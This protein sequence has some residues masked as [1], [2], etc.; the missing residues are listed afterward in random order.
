MS[1][2]N[3][4]KPCPFCG[5]DDYDLRNHQSWTGMRYYVY[6]VEVTHHCPAG[7]D[8][9]GARLTI[10]GKTAQDAIDRWNKRYAPVTEEAGEF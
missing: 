2:S 9:F 4:V 5:G 10:Q 7:P 1:F 8:G 3:E 6:S